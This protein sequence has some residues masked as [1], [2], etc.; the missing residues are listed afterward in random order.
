MPVSLAEAGEHFIAV[1]YEL[2]RKHLEQDKHVGAHLENAAERRHEEFVR[3]VRRHSNLKVSKFMGLVKNEKERK[4][5]TK[6]SQE[7]IAAIA[8]EIAGVLHDPDEQ[9]ACLHYI[10]TQETAIASMNMEQLRAFLLN[11]L[12]P[13]TV[14]E[15][16]KE[17]KFK[18]E[19]ETTVKNTC[20]RIQ[21]A[22]DKMEAASSDS[23]KADISSEIYDELDSLIVNVSGIL[24]AHPN[25]RMSAATSNNLYC[26]MTDHKP[27]IP[28]GSDHH[29]KHFVESEI[30]A[31]IHGTHRKLLHEMKH[32]PSAPRSAARYVRG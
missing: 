2:K 7:N 19:V 1:G 23:D 5:L 3:K 21:R 4:K 26:L 30:L 29:H 16:V 32:P 28:A 10:P 24:D 12:P 31:A 20:D 15:L 11:Y 18:I 27:L 14:S 9:Y 8:K 6:A 13:H 22:V 25:L 17:I